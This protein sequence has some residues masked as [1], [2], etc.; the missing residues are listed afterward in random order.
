M[1][2]F[3]ARACGTGGF[4]LIELLV[5]VAIIAILAAL[6]LPALQQAR[7]SAMAVACQGNLRQ[8][9]LGIHASAEE[10]QGSFA[11]RRQL[12]VPGWGSTFIPWGFGIAGF[13]PYWAGAGSDNFTKHAAELRPLLSGAHMSYE[14]MRCPLQAGI[15]ANGGLSSP[16]RTYGAFIGAH[17]YSNGGFHKPYTHTEPDWALAGLAYNGTAYTAW[18]GDSFWWRMDR[19][20]WG[21]RTGLLA[22]VAGRSSLGHRPMWVSNKTDDDG[23]TGKLFL[24]H[25]G[26]ANIAFADGHVGAHV[27]LDSERF[28]YR[29]NAFY[30]WDMKRANQTINAA[31]AFAGLTDAMV[32]NFK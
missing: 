14:A 5:V 17:L 10:R 26:R 15:A 24:S 3:R 30:P 23:G 28:A 9:M 16:A 31:T 21:S 20:K 27:P 4:T 6:L 2:P 7:A 32:I 25:A 12:R 19:L 1:R 8:S 11:A 13:P 29:I 22:D 18:S